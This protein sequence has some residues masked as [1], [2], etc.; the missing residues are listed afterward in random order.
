[1]ARA[2]LI[3]WGAIV[4]SLVAYALAQADIND[5]GL[6]SVCTNLAL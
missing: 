1:M 4:L 2:S 5:D 6:P 3:Y